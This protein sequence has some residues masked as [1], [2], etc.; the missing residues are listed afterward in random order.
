MILF[1][2]C[3]YDLLKAPFTKPSP[4]INFPSPLSKHPI[5][6]FYSNKEV[7][8]SHLRSE[9][10]AYRR[11]TACR[12]ASQFIFAFVFLVLTL[13]YTQHTETHAR[14]RPSITCCCAGSV[15]PCA[16]LSIR[17]AVLSWYVSPSLSFS[18][19]KLG[20]SAVAEARTAAVS[21]VSTLSSS[22]LL[23]SPSLSNT[24]CE[25]PPI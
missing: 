8:L 12:R 16:V 19:Y 15:R 13:I 14:T 7:S 21:L 10:T 2:N 11:V 5:L 6:Y 9:F 3:V 20:R 25:S 17:G 1:G 23:R 18:L 4:I 24:C 22:S